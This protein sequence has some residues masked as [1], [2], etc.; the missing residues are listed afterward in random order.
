MYG[1]EHAMVDTNSS[2]PDPF[3]AEALSHVSLRQGAR[4]LDLAC[5]RGRHALEL[6]RQG[7]SVEAWD[8]NAEALAE[9]EAQARTEELAISTREVDCEVP[10]RAGPFDLVLI[11]NYLDRTLPPRLLPSVRS[12]GFLIYCTFT[13]D[14]E[15]T[16]PS[17]RWCVEPG[18]LQRGFEGWEILHSV[19]TSGRAGI[20][21][22][23][24]AN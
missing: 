14:R 4:V 17:D 23:R 21:A 1:V 2:Q 18:E 11:F 16:H 9:L 15:G 10:P 5:G 8:R 6:A 19:E 22:R 13:L 3:L 12:G 7:F 20:V 24:T